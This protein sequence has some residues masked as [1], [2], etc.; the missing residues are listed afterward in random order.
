[1][2]KVIDYGDIFEDA[3]FAHGK[4]NL[5][6]AVFP[7]ED[8]AQRLDGQVA[9][10]RVLYRWLSC[11]C[12]RPED[13]AWACVKGSEISYWNRDEFDIEYVEEG[14]GTLFDVFDI[15]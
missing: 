15:L 13:E 14:R 9:D 12:E 3:V 5:F 1:M 6:I 4:G 8:K 2:D 11:T 10:Y 7:N